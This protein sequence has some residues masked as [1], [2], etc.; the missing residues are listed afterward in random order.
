[1]KDVGPPM[2][3]VTHANHFSSI[4]GGRGMISESDL[5]ELNALAP[6][7]FTPG[8]GPSADPSLN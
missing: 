7:Y 2:H 8:W 6:A 4:S 1:M 3:K 5:A